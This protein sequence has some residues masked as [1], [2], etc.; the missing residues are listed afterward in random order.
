MALYSLLYK[1]AHEAI[2]PQPLLGC[3]KEGCSSSFFLVETFSN[4]FLI[5]LILNRLGPV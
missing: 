2:A 3:S 1:A 4:S 5:F